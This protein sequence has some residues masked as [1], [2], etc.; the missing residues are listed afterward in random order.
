[1]SYQES[2]DVGYACLKLMGHLD[3][4]EHPINQ[5]W[6]CHGLHKSWASRCGDSFIGH[7]QPTS[8]DVG[9]SRYFHGSAD[10]SWKRRRTSDIGLNM[11]IRRISHIFGDTFNSNTVYI[12]CNVLEIKHIVGGHPYMCPYQILTDVC[13]SF[14][15]R[16]W[17]ISTE[18]NE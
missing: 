8:A 6:T 18:Q 15:F 12:W 10:V 7:G 16:T 5:P 4:S 17:C 11:R 9:D 2:K 13:K 3:D 1:M 14:G